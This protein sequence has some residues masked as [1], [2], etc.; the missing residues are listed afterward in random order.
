MSSPFTAAATLQAA[1]AQQPIRDP[2]A[3]NSST[4]GRNRNRRGR[5]GAQN[6]TQQNGDEQHQV[7]GGE[8]GR[9]RGGNRPRGTGRGR[10]GRGGINGNGRGEYNSIP[11]QLGG[12]KTGV[13]LAD[14]NSQNEVNPSSSS[15]S[16]RNDSRPP[17]NGNGNSRRSRFNASLSNGNST[18]AL[19]PTAS[20]FV[21]PVSTSSSGYSTPTPVNQT[22]TER[23]TQELTSGS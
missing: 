14:P 18:G 5:G 7:N 10:G 21:P 13:N 15:T 23:L 12:T 4:R 6:Q 8:R 3:T 1:S 9:G 19:H 20:P 22:L 16:A 11:S 17:R 2:S